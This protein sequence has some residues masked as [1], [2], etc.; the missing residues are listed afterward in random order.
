MKWDDAGGVRNMG[1]GF[2]ISGDGLVVTNAHVVERFADGAVVITLDGGD[3]L[4]VC[5]YVFVYVCV[6]HVCI[7][8]QSIY[9][10]LY[11]CAGVSNALSCGY[12]IMQV[13]S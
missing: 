3:K 8:Q 9:V 13:F 2:I 4:K 5:A 12:Y 1:S 10:V 7:T 11:V 6:V